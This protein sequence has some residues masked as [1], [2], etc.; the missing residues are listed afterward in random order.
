MIV[1]AHIGG[2]PIEELLIPWV[3]GGLGTGILLAL[4]AG[5]GGLKRSLPRCKTKRTPS[6]LR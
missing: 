4:A 6:C 2:V 1:L 5:L 3:S